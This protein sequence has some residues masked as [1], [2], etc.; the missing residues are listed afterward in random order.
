MYLYLQLKSCESFNPINQGS[1]NCVRDWRGYRPGEWQEGGL[2][3]MPV[4]YEQKA[5]AA[6]NALIIQK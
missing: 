6:G 5:R 1:D 4:Q 2:R 3:L